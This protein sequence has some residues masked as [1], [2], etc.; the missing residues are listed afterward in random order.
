[1]KDSIPTDVIQ[2]GAAGSAMRMAAL[3]VGVISLLGGWF[4][5]GGG[6]SGH[7]TFFRSYLVNFTFFLS[8]G[9]GA[10]F[11]VMV[12][13]LMRAGWNITVRRVAE[14][15]A[16]G[17][18][19]MMLLAVPV[20]LG[21][22]SL[23]EWTH[24]DVVAADPMLQHKAAWLN[25][26]FFLIRL[27]AYFALWLLMTWYF[28]SRSTRQDVS[29]DPQLTLNMGKWAGPG[30]MLFA[31]T[32]SFASF[33]LLMSL[34]PHW[35]STIFGVYYF[36]GAV[37]GSCAMLTLVVLIF[38]K[39]G[40]FGNL[41]NAEHY[42]DL[43]KLIFAFTVFWA[44]I[45]FSQYF[46]IWYGNMPEETIWYLK[47]Q[48]GQWTTVTLVLLF[49]HFMVPFLGLMSRHIKRNSVLLMLWA[50]W[51]LLMHWLDMYWIVMPEFSAGVVPFGLADVLTFLGVGGI[52]LSGSL[53]FCCRHPLIP[54]EDP[55]L[56]EA[57]GFE[58]A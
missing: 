30:V 31:V 55:R 39:M 9:L 47:R 26:N 53:H 36:A 7:D 11:F 13:Q 20:Y 17:L 2:L 29:G 45:G 28:T 10:L 4:L 33:D 6:E 44:Y 5:T 23:F 46:L 41:V 8:I 37:V 40:K 34:A 32:L 50:S 3:V 19:M 48:T 27:V 58:N 14:G 22:H 15:L 51:M 18:W 35:Y 12:G 56:H 1:M 21:R 52:Y 16:S 57:I 38:Q 25:D 42:Q 24:A 43:G 49:G 54:L